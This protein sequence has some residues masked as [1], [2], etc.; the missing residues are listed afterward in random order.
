MQFKVFLNKYISNFFQAKNESAYGNDLVKIFKE[1]RSKVTDVLHP[2]LSIHSRENE[3]KI[4]SPFSHLIY[5]IT[6]SHYT[7]HRF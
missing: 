5:F 2:F 6:N 4:M 1:N 7:Q 3:G